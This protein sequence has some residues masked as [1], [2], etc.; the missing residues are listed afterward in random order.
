M[1]VSEL[2]PALRS[3]SRDEKWQVMQFLVSELQKEEA[4]LL[5]A[6]SECPVWSPFNS[7]DAASSLLG[8]LK[9]TEAPVNAAR[10]S[11]ERAQYREMPCHPHSHE[12]KAS[13]H[14][15]SASPRISPRKSGRA[16]T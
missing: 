16:R 6:G 7:F 15:T 14:A 5:T 9:A 1:S 10:P 2:L 3:L 11:A 8:V 12:R 4:A 13:A